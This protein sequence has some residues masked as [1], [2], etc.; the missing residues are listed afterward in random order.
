VRGGAVKFA[1][2]IVRD[3]AREAVRA[4]LEPGEEVVAVDLWR[5]P[6][7]TRNA[8]DAERDLHLPETMYAF[9]TSRRLL[10]Y[11]QSGHGDAP[12]GDLADQI[13]IEDVEAITEHRGLVASIAWRMT[14]RVRGRDYVL[15]PLNEPWLHH[16]IEGLEQVKS[17]AP[18]GSQARAQ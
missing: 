8:L 2:D 18:L 12:L 6:R 3:R 4:F 7:R 15:I 14:L 13:P 9:L 5:T 1:E 16:M 11:E 17:G 10:I